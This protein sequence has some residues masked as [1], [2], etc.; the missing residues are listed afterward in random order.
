[1]SS[2]LL[3]MVALV[4]LAAC[5]DAP[6]TS[7]VGDV[8]APVGRA[9]STINA[10]PW[11][12]VY[13]T[14]LNLKALLVYPYGQS[15]ASPKVVNLPSEPAG[16]IA[17]SRGSVYVALPKSSAVAVYSSGGTKLL[18]TI[19]SGVY[20][21]HGVAVDTT[22][23]LY[24]SN[25]CAGCDPYVLTF[26]R[27]ASKPSAN[28][29]AYFANYAC[30]VTPDAQG[31][32]WL[33]ERYEL[34]SSAFH[35]VNGSPNVQLPLTTCRGIVV[36]PGGNA[37]VADGNGVFRWARN[38]G[39][40]GG[41]VFANYGAGHEVTLLTMARDGTMVVPVAAPTQEGGPFVQIRLPGGASLSGDS[42]KINNGIS[43]PQ[44]AAVGK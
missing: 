7:P 17:D 39:P 10:L 33:V 38:A 43:S 32:I 8:P 29:R 44:G 42:Y 21:P 13:V 5:S 24:V 36:D 20:M 12:F 19:T 6:T 11:K 4:S 9:I 14:D 34:E 16:V 30:G 31:G 2:R 40:S 1:M 3:C 15:G 35:Y 23:N 26:H 18:R 22:D 27:G 28:M 25:D 41:K 37:Y